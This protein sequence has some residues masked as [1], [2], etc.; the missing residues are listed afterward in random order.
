MTQLVENNDIMASTSFLMMASFQYNSWNFR[1]VQ[2]W[3][4]DFLIN[5]PQNDEGNM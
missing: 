3:I 1:D 2:G 5:E 4:V